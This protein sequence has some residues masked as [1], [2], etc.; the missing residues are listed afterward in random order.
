MLRYTDSVEALVLVETLGLPPARLRSV[1]ILL[2]RFRLRRLVKFLRQP[3]S[4]VPEECSVLF[5]RLLPEERL[6]PRY[7]LTRYRSCQSAT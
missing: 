5:R 1:G 2:L 7:I 4:R 6:R 3:E